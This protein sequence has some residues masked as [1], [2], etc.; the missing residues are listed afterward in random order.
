MNEIQERFL[1]AL[2]ASMKGQSV[3]WKETLKTKQWKEL[4]QIAETHHVL[5]LIYEAVAH[6]QA[7]EQADSQLMAAFKW[8]IVQQVSMQALKT[9]SFL[10][11]LEYLNKNDLFPITV[12]GIICRSLYPNP[13]HRISG[14][15]DILILQEQYKNYH[16]AFI[17]SGLQVVNEEINIEE[18]FEVAYMAK[19]G[20]LYIEVHKDL[21]S[22]ESDAYGDFN[23]F[24]ER[25]QE[26][27]SE[28]EIDGRMVRTLGHT[29]HFFY[30]ICH[31]FKHFLHS[32]FGI[33]QVCDIILYAEH[34][35]EEIDWQ[36][37]LEQCQEIHAEYFTAALFKIGSRY[38][39][40]DMER[41]CVPQEWRLLKVDETMMLEELLT[42]G[43]Y[44][45]ESRSRM[46][47]S[48]ITLNAVSE[49]WHGK[50]GNKVVKTIF[51]PR[52]ALEK[53]YPY[54]KKHGW[55]LPAAWMQ[56]IFGYYRESKKTPNNDMLRSL[57][58]GKARLDLMRIYKII[59]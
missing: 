2:K 17:E 25:A 55:L 53:K 45:Y 35:G 54:L 4:F 44:G 52:A 12:K 23:R 29:D 10:C 21:F 7:A 26:R 33:R 56:R 43:I 13:D 39:A 51:L 40:F 59:E 47:S 9:E 18:E 27:M 46:H 32:G 31:A 28:I 58:I 30:L 41:A 50:K 42:A 8:K 22:S 34:Y 38:L 5:P 11:L 57:Q 15:E 36:Q 3:S 6:S 20:T 24:F 48:N 1:E 16:Q 19:K 37:V 49:Q 14:D